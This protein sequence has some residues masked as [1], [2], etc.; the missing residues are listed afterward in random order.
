MGN[1]VG[2]DPTLSLIVLIHAADIAPV[3][4]EDS[5][6]AYNGKA[7]ALVGP[8]RIVMQTDLATHFKR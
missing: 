1:E 6:H 4:W 7:W 5:R 8:L 2:E 3:Q